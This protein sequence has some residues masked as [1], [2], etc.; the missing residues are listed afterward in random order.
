MMNVRFISTLNLSIG[1]PGVARVGNVR[2]NIQDF[3]FYEGRTAC[4]KA[5]KR[6]VRNGKR[7]M[8]G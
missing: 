6:N 7:K 5:T 8:D 1:G 2:G 3:T 4:K